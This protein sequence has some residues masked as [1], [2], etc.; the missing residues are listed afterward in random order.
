MD[1][2]KKLID[3]QAQPLL[4]QKLSPQAKTPTK[5]SKDA[6]G[7]DLFSNNLPINIQPNELQLGSTGIAFKYPKGIYGKFDP[8]SGH[9][10]KSHL[11]VLAGDIGPD[12]TGEIIVVF[13]ILVR[14]YKR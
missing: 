11:N 10:I 12:Y 4:V 7:Y 13:S 2:N 8:H 5:R 6:I 9:T 3:N 1:E 14:R